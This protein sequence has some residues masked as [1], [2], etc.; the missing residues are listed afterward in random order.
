MADLWLGTCQKKML[1]S[2]VLS[3]I[4]CCCVFFVVGGFQINYSFTVHEFSKFHTSLT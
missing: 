2:L 1:Y 4:V 3:F